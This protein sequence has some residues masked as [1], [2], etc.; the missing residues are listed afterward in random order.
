MGNS[1]DSGKESKKVVLLANSTWNIYN[2]RRNIIRHCLFKGY[3]VTVVAPVDRY[4]SYLEEFPQVNHIPLKNLRRN[5]KRPWLDL[6]CIWELCRLFQREK[7]H[8]ALS[9]TVK[10]NIYTAIAAK[11]ACVPAIAVITGLGYT[12][13]HKG[14]VPSLTQFLYKLTG[15]WNRRFI[16]ENIDDRVL[17]AELGIIPYDKSISIKGC[18]VDVDFFSPNGYSPDHANGKFVYTFLGRLLYDKGI[19]EFLE[20]AKLVKAEFPSAEFWLV[21][22]VDAQNPAS[23]DKSFLRQ[24]LELGFITH[25]GYT[26]QVKK[27]I[28]LSDCIVLPSYREA[29]PRSLTES[30]AMEK[31]VITTDTAGCREAVEE[32]KNGFKVPIKNAFELA[33]A[34]KRLMLM[35]PDERLQMGIYGR[36]KAVWE[37]CDERIAEKVVQLADEILAVHTVPVIPVHA[38]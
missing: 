19:R 31:P 33:E 16:F 22:D 36:S 11:V 29:I 6:F 9:F 27:M 35:S 17:F 3:N 1:Y 25:W 13:L 37:F 12:F 21:G 14:L 30:M 24:Y 10:L 28:G 18:G 15:P 38:A 7:F 32:G 5:S 20:A 34:M 4:I 26:D 23:V 8:L 2:F